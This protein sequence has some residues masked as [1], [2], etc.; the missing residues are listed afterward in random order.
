M[1]VSTHIC[2]DVRGIADRVI[3]LSD[4]RIAFDGPALDLEAL[5]ID[6]GPGVSVFENGYL[7]VLAGHH[8]NAT[9]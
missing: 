1:L 3:V 4:G 9:P 5:G 7:A 8:G 2:E 6:G